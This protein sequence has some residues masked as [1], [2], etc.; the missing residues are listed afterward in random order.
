MSPRP[1][2]RDAPLSLFR[3]AL[4]QQLPG[5]MDEVLLSDQSYQT[6]VAYYR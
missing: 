1:K 6:P 2:R 3:K 4:I 5:D